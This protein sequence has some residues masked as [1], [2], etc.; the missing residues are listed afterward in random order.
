MDAPWGADEDELGAL[1]ASPSHADSLQVGLA[2]VVCVPHFLP[3]ARHCRGGG[4]LRSHSS[5]S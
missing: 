5:S 4:S 3:A 1:L 2:P